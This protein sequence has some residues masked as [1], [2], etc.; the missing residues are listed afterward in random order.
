MHSLVHSVSAIR[1]HFGTA[2][3]D[4]KV[5]ARA[6]AAFQW[7]SMPVGAGEPQVVVTVEETLAF[8]S[9]RQAAGDLLT[10][11]SIQLV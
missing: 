9:N 6:A 8:V 4:R 10:V 1:M 5:A 2:A 7:L 3:F 11:Q